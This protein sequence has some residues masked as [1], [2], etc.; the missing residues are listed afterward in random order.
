MT[1]N[2]TNVKKKQIMVAETLV[3]TGRKIPICV[4]NLDENRIT[5][6]KGEQTRLLKC[7]VRV[8]HYEKK[9]SEKNIMYMI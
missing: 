8:I 9:I 1:E 6:N 2:A 4:A 5:L 7:V 3:E